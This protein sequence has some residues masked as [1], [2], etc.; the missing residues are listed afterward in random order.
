MSVKCGACRHLRWLAA[1]LAGMLV[2]ACVPPLLL[3]DPSD[4]TNVSARRSVVASP[5]YQPFSEPER[6]DWREANDELR[7][8]FAPDPRPDSGTHRPTVAPSSHRQH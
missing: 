8:Q 5:V 6:R 2:A 4:P 7:Q 3:P 1:G